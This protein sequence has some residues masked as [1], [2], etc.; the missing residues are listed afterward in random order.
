[1]VPTLPTEREIT[2]SDLKQVRF[3]VG[4]RG[5]RMDQVD[6][7]L[8]RLGAQLDGDIGPSDRL[9]S[10]QTQNHEVDPAGH[11][12]EEEAAAIAE[13]DAPDS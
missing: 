9:D 4:L 1:V 13:S 3:A 8:D 11:I 7:L 12:A 2:G 10:Y 5:Y 6:A